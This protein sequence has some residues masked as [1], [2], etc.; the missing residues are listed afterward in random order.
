MDNTNH[1]EKRK[2]V[3]IP[4][5]LFLA[6]RTIKEA[7]QFR[8]SI[9]ASLESGSPSSIGA[10]LKSIDDQFSMILHS[11]GDRVPKTAELITLLNRKINLI[12]HHVL[13][14]EIEN[15]HTE[16]EVSISAAGIG[17]SYP[18]PLPVSEYV[19]IDVMLTL[20]PYRIITS[21]RITSC[22]A[23]SEDDERSARPEHVY[24][25][26]AE[27][28]ALSETDEEMLIQHVIRRQ[29]QLLK[30]QRLLKEQKEDR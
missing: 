11:L 18:Q 13:K 21:A 16:Q 26:R 30:Q 22:E 7:E 1:F 15:D 12:T 10:Q 24:Y 28:N 5:T 19:A 6:V 20:N 23:I 2:F 14:K 17:F 27:F 29:S 8:K 3:R 4:D 25:I 9:E